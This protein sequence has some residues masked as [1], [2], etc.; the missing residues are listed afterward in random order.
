MAN[1]KKGFSFGR[2][3]RA[4]STTSGVEVLDETLSNKKKPARRENEMLSSVMNE[5]TPGPALDRVRSN[6]PFIVDEGDRR[7][8]VVVLVDTE[9]L[10]GLNKKTASSSEEKGSFLELVR[11]EQI[12][13]IATEEMLEV[14]EFVIIPNEGTV[15]RLQEFRMM[16]EIPYEVV[17]VDLADFS[18]DRSGATVGFESFSR[19][20]DE[21]D[22]YEIMDLMDEVSMALADREEDPGDDEVQHEFEAVETD[23][24]TKTEQPA[25]ADQD[26][27][28][29]EPVPV[30]VP[31]D[32]PDLGE[33][34]SEDQQAPEEDQEEPEGFEEPEPELSEPLADDEVEVDYTDER[35]FEMDPFELEDPESDYEI[36]EDEDEQ[37]AAQD[38]TEDSEQGA[39]LPPVE[40]EVTAEQQVNTIVRRMQDAELNLE[41]PLAPF[42]TRFGQAETPVA[43]PVLQE[44][45]W[46]AQVLAPAYEAANAELESMHREGVIGLRQ[47]Y[48]SSL[49][50]VATTILADCATNNPETPFGKEFAEAREKYRQDTEQH[51]TQTSKLQR[52]LMEAFEE[53]GRRVGELARLNA[54]NAYR[55]Q[56]RPRLDRQLAEAGE[57]LANQAAHQLHA[58]E[59]EINVRRREE[60]AAIMD[61]AI[62]KALDV[63]ER[64]YADLLERMKARH[65]ELADRIEQQT[66]DIRRDEVARATSIEQQE[67][68]R[69]ELASARARSEQ[70]L[71]EAQLRA[72][73]R[74]RALQEELEDTRAQAENR[75]VTLRT[76]M[77]EAMDSLSRQGEQD[78]T[79]KQELQRQLQELDTIKEDQYGQRIANLSSEV[80]RYRT[81]YE[82]ELQNQAAMNRRMIMMFIM[83]AV[84]ALLVGAVVGM[85]FF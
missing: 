52:E 46:S 65:S 71:H 45:T 79:E 51:E 54:E 63:A 11:S 26:S 27:P 35:P 53:E 39:E 34:F 61:M 78:R 72:E 21:A 18:M 32:E 43:F 23:Q 15:E 74:V 6:E 55:Q 13:V 28:E 66:L 69:E 7:F 50:R 30:V 3:R 73:E 38:T 33:G 8:G 68:L 77:Q 81:D 31:E 17:M 58:T 84:V 64:N 25:Q 49:E 19:M 14:D 10:G 76:Q 2:G 16:H 40:G 37:D 44:D 12:S 5:S 75:L 24:D 67:A 9:D 60:S 80:D 4:K 20:F 41:V 36:P 48:A 85:M 82:Q 62:T 56:N 57:R 29:T 83:I 1:K 47:A 22:D 59:R 70:A 42:E